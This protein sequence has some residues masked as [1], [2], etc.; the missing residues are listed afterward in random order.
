MHVLSF[1]LYF[2]SYCK[3]LGNVIRTGHKKYT[4]CEW[5]NKTLCS[6]W[7]DCVWNLKEAGTTKNSWDQWGCRFKGNVQRSIWGLLHVRNEEMEFEVK[8]TILFTLAN[9]NEVLRFKSNRFSSILER[10]SL[11]PCWMISYYT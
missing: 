2:T 9:Q 10:N 1:Q 4:R 3:T 11:Q 6:W 8:N 7:Y 5:W